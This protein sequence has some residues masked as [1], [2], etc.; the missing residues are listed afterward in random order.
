MLQWKCRW[1][2]ELFTGPSPSERHKRKLTLPVPVGFLK[3][4]LVQSAAVL[5]LIYVSSRKRENPCQQVKLCSGRVCWTKPQTATDNPT[6]P[7][8]K[9][10]RHW[11]FC[12]GSW[13]ASMSLSRE[14]CPMLCPDA[15]VV[16]RQTAEPHES[17]AARCCSW[18]FVWEVELFCDPRQRKGE[19]KNKLNIVCS[20]QNYRI[21][22]L[23]STTTST[24]SNTQKRT[25][26]LLSF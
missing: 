8:R 24:T 20:A 14:L 22:I 19:I 21:L 16:L 3:P 1:R 26:D 25:L 23:C 5:T 4:H 9:Q 18:L 2:Q 15:F 7:G 10:S 13:K 17:S 6:R 12:L 11:G